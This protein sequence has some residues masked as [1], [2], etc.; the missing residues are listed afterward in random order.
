M[1]EFEIPAEEPETRKQNIQ[2]GTRRELD[3]MPCDH[4]FWTSEDNYELCH[5]TGYEES[6]GGEWWNEYVDR[7]GNFHY[8]R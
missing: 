2:D 4:G 5:A 8:G 6:H 3:R 1:F 7:D